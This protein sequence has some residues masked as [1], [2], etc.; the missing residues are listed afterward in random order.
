M[1]CYCVARRSG[2]CVLDEFSRF[3]YIV[4]ASMGIQLDIS[5]WSKNCGPAYLSKYTIM[6]S[7]WVAFS[8]MAGYIIFFIIQNDP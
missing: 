3:E 7:G 4:R 6:V 5:G 1:R 2:Y 8:L